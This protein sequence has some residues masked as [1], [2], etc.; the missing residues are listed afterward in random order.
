MI[1]RHARRAACIQPY[2]IALRSYSSLRLR[3]AELS[4]QQKTR[5]SRLSL[6]KHRSAQQQRVELRSQWKQAAPAHPLAQHPFPRPAKAQGALR[7]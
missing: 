5:Q 4:R 3:A 6:R 7:L 2:R 1:S